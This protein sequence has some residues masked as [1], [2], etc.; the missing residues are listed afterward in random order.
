MGKQDSRLTQEE[1]QKAIARLLPDLSGV[2][3]I[4]V[5]RSLNQQAAAWLV[6]RNA[7]V[8]RDAPGIARDQAGRYDA[9][10]L[11][12]W[13][14]RRA[15]RPD[16][17]P[18]DVEKLMVAVE[19]IEGELS[20]VL[21]VSIIES[22]ERVHE[23]YGDSAIVAFADLFIEIIK[24]CVDAIRAFERQPRYQEE[25]EQEERKREAL[26]QRIE[27]DREA[28]ESLRVAYYCDTHRMLRQGREWVKAPKP[29]AG[30]VIDLV[31]C[32]KCE[33]SRPA[34]STGAQKNTRS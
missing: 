12:R 17:A 5:M 14:V 18:A 16:L 3:Q 21:L 33:G 19:A 29:P 26:R 25:L 2:Q 11:V 27:A 1:R 8:L 23:V 20:G 6:D 32:P 4:E 7:R 24:P 15:P 30:F 13:A 28:R 34:C 22:L 31:A 10:D 9:Q